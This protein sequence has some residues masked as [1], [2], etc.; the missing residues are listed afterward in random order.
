MNP[1]AV[2]ARDERA[3]PRAMLRGVSSP[4]PDAS[5][6][7]FSALIDAKLQSDREVE[8][9]RARVRAL[10]TQLTS[11]EERVCASIARD[12]HDE[13]G[14][15]LT[16]ANL[17]IARAQFSLPADAPA[18]C[19][20]ALRQ[21]RECLAEAADA[22][23][24]IV[25][26][27][28][29]P[30]FPNGLASALAEWIAGFGARTGIRVNLSWVVEIDSGRLPNDMALALFRVTQEALGNVARHAQATQAI[31]S[32]AADDCALTLAVEDDGI[33]ITQA[34]RRKAG[35]FGL[36]GM[37]SRCEAFG[38]SLRVV[39]LKAGGTCVRARLPFAAAPRLALR[40]VNA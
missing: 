38:G 39:S 9:L 13:T 5:S 30:S 14:A 21:A 3:T 27:M 34:A 23:H 2:V 37:R 20:E 6:S 24:R 18:A 31:V 32:V 16:A 33:G 19:A 40:A 35:R 15:I 36:A 7:P 1:L 28:H 8:R 25:E 22:S 4:T 10:A 12:L 29:A 11:A 26:G 17:A